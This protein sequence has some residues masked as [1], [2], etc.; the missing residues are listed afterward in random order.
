MGAGARSPPAGRRSNSTRRRGDP[1]VIVCLDG[2]TTPSH[3]NSMAADGW[4]T[5]QPLRV[6][7]NKTD[8]GPDRYARCDRVR[9]FRCWRLPNFKLWSAAHRAGQQEVETGLGSGSP[10]VVIRGHDQAWP[11]SQI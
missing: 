9:E 7:A 8:L 1:D 6:T 5:D 11:E 4:G 10:R 2:N 3:T